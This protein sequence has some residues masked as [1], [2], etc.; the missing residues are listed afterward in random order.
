[1]TTITNPLSAIRNSLSIDG[2]VHHVFGIK[3]FRPLQLEAVNADWGMRDSLVVMPTGG[4]K[5]LCYQLPAVARLKGFLHPEGMTLVVSPLIALMED[6]IDSLN[7][8]GI[9]AACLHSKQ[10]PRDQANIEKQAKRGELALLYV[11]P[12][13][14]ISPQF[15]DLFTRCRVASVVID[16]AHCI[17]QWGHDFRPAYIKLGDLRRV[18]P[19]PF[20]AFTATATPQVRREIVEQLHLSDPVVLIGDFDRPNLFLSVVDR[21]DLDAQLLD[22]VRARPGTAGIV[23]CITRAETERIARMLR[24]AGIPAKHY[25]GDLE[26]DERAAVHDWFMDPIRNPQS[27]TTNPQVVVATI[28]FGMGIDKPDVRWVIHAAMPSS[29]EVYHQEIGRAGRDGKPAECVL[30]YD[31][32]DFHTWQCRLCQETELFGTTV[33]AL[34][35]RKGELLAHMVNYCDDAFCRHQQLVEYFDQDLDLDAVCSACDVCVPDDE[36]LKRSNVQTG[37]N[38]DG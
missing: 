19:V 11:S 33:Q 24:D 6:Q 14:L 25:H 1:M 16:E 26:A 12:E 31:P 15:I 18:L 32:N 28:A 30:L 23:Y 37:I 13:R 29:I 9:P 17:S 4:G 21:T 7:D 36:E 2:L 35:E 8:T 10:H 38:A 22:F 5:S 3:A 34:D 20:H 27:P